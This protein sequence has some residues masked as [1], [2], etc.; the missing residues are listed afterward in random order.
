M[1][2][3]VS[4]NHQGWTV[5]FSNLK[6][7]FWIS[8]ARYRPWSSEIILSWSRCNIKVGCLI[9][10]RSSVTSSVYESSKS[11]AATSRLDDSLWNFSKLWVSA[12]SAPGIKSSVM[13]LDPRP[14][15]ALISETKA[16]LTSSLAS[17][18][19]F[20]KDPYNINLITLCGLRWE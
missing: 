17:V 11:L 14:H 10:G 15:E 8:E 13:V 12:A 7:A 16:D 5:P 4:P 19:P 18:C 6:F 9:S 20:A 2:S 1:I 3:S